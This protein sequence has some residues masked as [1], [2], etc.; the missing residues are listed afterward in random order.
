[1]HANH[2]AIPRRFTTNKETYTELTFNSLPSEIRFPIKY[3]AFPQAQQELPINKQFDSWWGN[4][5]VAL[6][7]SPREHG[8]GRARNSDEFVCL[9]QISLKKY[10]FQMIAKD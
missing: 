9:H 4:E 3:L 2:F 8:G 10:M 5:P 7:V 1:M 6:S